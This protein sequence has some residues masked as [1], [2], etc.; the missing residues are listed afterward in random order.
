MSKP[1]FEE[2]CDAIFRTRLRLDGKCVFCLEH[3]AADEEFRKWHLKEK[4]DIEL[5]TV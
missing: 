1:T 4:H 2:L 5:E 3:L